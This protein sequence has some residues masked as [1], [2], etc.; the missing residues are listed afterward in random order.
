VYLYCFPGR[1][2]EKVIFF[3]TLSSCASL[4]FRPALTKIYLSDMRKDTVIARRNGTARKNLCAPNDIRLHN[5]SHLH[6]MVQQLKPCRVF[7]CPMYCYCTLHK[8]D[9]ESRGS[10][11]NTSVS[12]LVGSGFISYL[13][14]THRTSCYK[15]M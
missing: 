5:C 8:Q 10:V 6:V 9:S 13:G 14:T 11:V 12:Y 7:M 2:T 1:G 3:F 4:N 15:L